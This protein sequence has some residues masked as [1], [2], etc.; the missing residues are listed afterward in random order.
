[1]REILF[2]GKR[3][4]SNGWVYGHPVADIYGA[5]Y[6]IIIHSSEYNDGNNVDIDYDF[7][8]SETV[9]QYT[10]LTD[11]N[12]KKIFE[13][14]I[15]KCISSFDAKDMVVI[16]EAAEFHLFDCQRYKNYTECCG[17][18]HFGTL[19]TEVIGNIHDNPELA[20]A[21]MT[22]ELKPCPFCGGK[23]TII[24]RDDDGNL[25][26]DDYKD[27]P[28]S[29][30]GYQIRHS[31]EENEDCPI[32]RYAED[33]AIMGS[34]YIYDTREE[35][36]KAWNRRYIDR[37][38]LCELAR[39]CINK[40]VDCNDIIRFPTADVREVEHA[41][42]EETSHITFSKRGRKIHSKMYNCSYCGAPNGRKKSNFCHWCGAKMDGGGK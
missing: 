29:G 7:V 18:R 27:D 24:Y 41:Q 20:G 25:H 11:K 36:I 4:D 2:R 21:V 14:D 32:A 8:I 33:G 15:V 3:I 34:V 1:M 5:K 39:N 26:G 40:T 22:E 23:A 35:A 37:E 38:K 19:E 16:F 12:G 31:H 13:G 17:Y 10:G 6:P 30:L 42:W 9:G 28:W